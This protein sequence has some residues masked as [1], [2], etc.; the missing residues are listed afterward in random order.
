MRFYSSCPTFLCY[1]E[2]GIAKEQEEDLSKALSRITNEKNIEELMGTLAQ[3]YRQG[4]EQGLMQRLEKEKYN[5]ARN[6]LKLGMDDQIITK[7]TGLH[8]AQIAQLKK[9]IES[10]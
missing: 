5:V 2:N 3:S 1:N 7:A 4:L 9:E 8:L 6:L 10:L